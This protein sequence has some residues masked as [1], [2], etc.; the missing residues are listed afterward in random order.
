M[1]LGKAEYDNERIEKLKLEIA[2]ESL[3]HHKG[4]VKFYEKEIVSF[5]R[6]EKSK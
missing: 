1:K 4:M 2:K 3:E 5:R 6:K